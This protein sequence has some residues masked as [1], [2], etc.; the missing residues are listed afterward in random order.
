VEGPNIIR[1]KGDNRQGHKGKDESTEEPVVYEQ[2]RM[3]V[4]QGLC[5]KEEDIAKGGISKT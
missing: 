4:C 3:E 2:Q 5:G 1:V